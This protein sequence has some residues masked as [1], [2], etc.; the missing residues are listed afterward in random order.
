MGSAL[1]VLGSS[2]TPAGG[3]HRI[4][5]GRGDEGRC[6][7]RCVREIRAQD[8][9]TGGR[10]EA[11]GQL[12]AGGGLPLDACAKPQEHH[13]RFLARPGRDEQCSR[14]GCDR[15]QWRSI[16]Q[17]HLHLDGPPLRRSLWGGRRPT[18]PGQTVLRLHSR[19]I[20]ALVTSWRLPLPHLPLAIVETDR[21][22]LPVR[23]PCR[24]R[25]RARE[26]VG[27]QVLQARRPVY[28]GEPVEGGRQK[29]RR[30]GIQTDGRDD[31]GVRVAQGLD[32]AATR[33]EVPQL[34]LGA[35]GRGEQSTAGEGGT[36]LHG[37]AV[38]HRRD[39]HRRRRRRFLPTA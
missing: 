32:N 8:D 26:L 38:V 31:L 2:A 23:P 4:V 10:Y 36:R 29:H 33:G 12:P 28:L 7:L 20:L 3:G 16:G 11:W 5:T 17:G 9:G 18:P 13:R 21:E 22:G 14:Q 6:Q 25:R 34:Y 30:R 35:A 39:G 24:A 27:P 1:F 19:A 15:R 37:A